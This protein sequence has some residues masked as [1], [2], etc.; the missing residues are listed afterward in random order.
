MDMSISMASVARHA[1]VLSV[2]ISSNYTD[3]LSIIYLAYLRLCQVEPEAAATRL[4]RP[5]SMYV[6]IAFVLS[7]PIDSELHLI[8]P[9]LGSRYAIRRN[10]M[11]LIYCW[12]IRLMIYT[13]S[14]CE[15]CMTSFK[16]DTCATSAFPHA[17]HGNVSFL[18][19]FSLFVTNIDCY[20]V[21]VMQSMHLSTGLMLSDKL[22]YA[23]IS[24]FRLCDYAQSYSV[25]FDAK[26]PQSC[27]PW[28]RARDV[29]HLEGLRSLIDC[30]SYSW[31][32]L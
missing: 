14:R 1:H 10:G 5:S 29:P 4:H 27:V 13:F 30:S 7:T 31:F 17:M 3:F 2:R 19:S 15:P 6:H 8:R 12:T 28:R 25:H 23:V 20:L 21:H 24:E 32:W 9:S 26:S 22:T 16:L 11:N 18:S